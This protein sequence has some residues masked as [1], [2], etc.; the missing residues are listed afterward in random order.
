LRSLQRAG[1]EA[2]S[3][4]RL[5][6]FLALALVLA[7]AASAEENRAL[8]IGEPRAAEPFTLAQR[9]LQAA[10]D[11]DR[12]TIERALAR[13]VA[14][15]AKD[16]LGRNALLLAVHDAGD[17]A[18]ARFLHEKGVALDLPDATGRA[19][20]SWAAADGRL[21]IARWLAESGAAIDRPD[22]ER[23]TPL[24][25]A[26]AGGHRDVA[27]FLLERGA[28]PN[29]ADRFGDTPL[30][31]ACAKGLNDVAALLLERGADPALRNQEGR[32]AADRAAPGADVCKGAGALR[33]PR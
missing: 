22:A 15:D 1:P 16:D 17:L 10:R 33:S 7:P 25:H 18:L 31:L 11:G 27:A 5:L 3:G 24:F 9:Y 19:A 23:R 6:A 13:G 21:E 29:A 2:R 20:L 4:L 12:R 28:D 32:A 14:A 30:I 26:A 8:G